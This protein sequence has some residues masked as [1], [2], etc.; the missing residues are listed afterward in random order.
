MKAILKFLLNTGTGRIIVQAIIGFLV[1]LFKKEIDKLEPYKK[2]NLKTVLDI[3][4]DKVCADVSD[5][6]VKVSEML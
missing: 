2:D 4:H 1:K 5:G 3:V 6:K